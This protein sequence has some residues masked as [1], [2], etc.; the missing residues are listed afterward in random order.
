MPRGA[1]PI[2]LA[3]T[4]AATVLAVWA[5]SHT[6]AAQRLPLR[7]LTTADGL[8][9]DQIECVRTDGR[10]FVWFCTPEGLARWDGHVA[11]TYGDR[12]GL[13]P[14]AV[15]SFS[16]TRSGRHWVGTDA[17]LFEFAATAPAGAPR[18]HQVRRHDDRRTGSVYA[19]AE[20]RDGSLWCGTGH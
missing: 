18:F 10:G 6:V 15:R 17:G 1:P 7:T 16:R 19:I 12:E 3:R 2:G 13:N 9:R 20:S 4:L 5:T 14:T 11:V 8:P